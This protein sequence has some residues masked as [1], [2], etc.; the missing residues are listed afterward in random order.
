[1]SKEV[2]LFWIYRTPTCF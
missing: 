2:R 1:M